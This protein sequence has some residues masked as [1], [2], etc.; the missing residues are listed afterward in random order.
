M[1]GHWSLVA[2]TPVSAA[3]M[4]VRVTAVLTGRVVES[5]LRPQIDRRQVCWRG[6]GTLH[7]G[8]GRAPQSGGGRVAA[9]PGRSYRDVA[10]LPPRPVDSLV[11]R[12]LQPAHDHA[13]RLGWVDD[14]V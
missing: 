10:V 14:I 11:P 3:V 2:S 1:A 13:S 9:G 5:S 4:T 12:L 8:G 6:G 7:Q